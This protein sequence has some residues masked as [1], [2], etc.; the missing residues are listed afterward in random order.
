MPN[1]SLL[2]Y[3]G[4]IL[5]E[6]KI[7]GINPGDILKLNG[8]FSGGYHNFRNEKGI[9]TR[10]IKDDPITRCQELGILMLKR[11]I[12]I[13][14][15]SRQ[16]KNVDKVG[17]DTKFLNDILEN[18]IGKCMLANE[19][20][21]VADRNLAFILYKLDLKIVNKFL[22]FTSI[23]KSST[24]PMKITA[25]PYDKYFTEIEKEKYRRE[26]RI[27]E[28]FDG[29]LD[30]NYDKQNVLRRYYYWATS[31]D[32]NPNRRQPIISERLRY[33]TYF[34]IDASYKIEQTNFDLDEKDVN[35]LTYI[36]VI[37]A[38]APTVVKEK[39]RISENYED[40]INKILYYTPERVRKKTIEDYSKHIK[41]LEKIA[42][43][44]YVECHFDRNFEK[45]IFGNT[46]CSKAFAKI[47]SDFTKCNF[48]RKNYR[49]ITN[50]KTVENDP[51]KL[52]YVSAKYAKLRNSETYRETDTLENVFKLLIIDDTTITEEKFNS[53]TYFS[54][55]LTDLI[56][57]YKYAFDFYDKLDKK[58]LALY[59]C[60]TTIRDIFNGLNFLISKSSGVLNDERIFTYFDIT[61]LDIDRTNS[62]NITFIPARRSYDENKER[63]RQSSKAGRVM[64]KLSI[65]YT[66]AEIEKFS[67]KFKSRV[68]DLLEPADIKLV[69]GSDI[70]YWYL[71]DRYLKEGGSLNNSCMRYKETQPRVK[72][73]DRYPDKISL[74]ILLTKD[75]EKLKGRAVV[76]K[77]D[78]G[79]LYMDRIYTVKS[80]DVYKFTEFAKDNKMLIRD[81]TKKKL[82]VTLPNE[83]NSDINFPYLDSFSKRKE[84]KKY[85]LTN[86]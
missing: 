25:I 23:D 37:Y 15:N 38:N 44:E 48:I 19:S 13:T 56:K 74:A 77:T 55:G 76:W 46:I 8:R 34:Q 83:D 22:P 80:H 49:K 73:Y 24:D 35:K 5:N 81:E 12:D 71:Q 58:M 17:S 36:N 42:S 43:N 6:A 66:E 2:K 33:I 60:S 62:S 30:E 9:V 75:G 63:Y 16:L 52:S 21:F 39:N 27:E 47:G 64:R 32:Q 84:Y 53:K 85:V 40:V 72:I 28:F 29:I 14:L 20:I 68:D 45:M 7:D 86:Y 18:K 26:Y 41:M 50:V 61:D 70:S 79:E 31:Q 69:N 57:G 67:E 3:K 11:G 51:N 1:N 10:K 59:K 78:S 4:F 65:R 54:E 82:T